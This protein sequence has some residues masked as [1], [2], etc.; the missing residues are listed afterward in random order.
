[1]KEIELKP[2]PFCGHE[3]IISEINNMSKRFVIHCENCVA[4]M[5]LRFVDAQLG[6]GSFISFYEARKVMDELTE[7][8]NRRADNDRT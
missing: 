1:M 6:D 5:E 8:W 4:A 7:C 2:C 3:H